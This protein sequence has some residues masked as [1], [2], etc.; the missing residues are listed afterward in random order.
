MPERRRAPATGNATRRERR[1]QPS[2]RVARRR[3]V[4]GGIVLLVAVVT[5]LVM[6][7]YPTRTYLQQRRDA[8]EA[9]RRLTSLQTETSKLRHDSE[10]LKGDAEVERIAR[11]QY[12]LVRPG[13]TTYVIV[14][15]AT[16]P[17][18]P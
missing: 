16:P 14:P 1:R 2:T 10:R 6:F 4:L 15:K 5:F 9:H 13:E 8:D 12:G 3:A 7:V 17:P 11:E 18:T